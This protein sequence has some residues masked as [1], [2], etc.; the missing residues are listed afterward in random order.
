VRPLSYTSRRSLLNRFVGQFVAASLGSALPSRIAAAD[1]SPPEPLR[2]ATALDGDTLKLASGATVRLIGI[3]APKP[4]LAPEDP[5]MASLAQGA[6]AALGRLA[7]RGVILRSDTLRQDRYGR[8]LAQAFDPDGVWLQGAQVAAGQARVHG[9]GSN[10][11]GLR[12]LL[13]L[14]DEARAARRG[15]WRHPAFAV[16]GAK[17]RVLWRLAGSFQIVTGRVTT[18]AIVRDTGYVNFGP[19]RHTDFTLV[20]RKPVLA[21]PDPAMLDLTR[22]NGRS[23]RCRGW[24]DLHDGPSMDLTCPE[25]MEVLEA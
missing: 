23:I 2:P 21:M 7:A 14:E 1:W 3:E 5:A 13:A 12:D 17:D 11:T 25:Q 20:V 10:R 15:L 18:A 22:L 16:R 24:I 6:T 9:D 19:D 4:A 8:L